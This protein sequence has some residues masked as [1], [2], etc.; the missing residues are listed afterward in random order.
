MRGKVPPGVTHCTEFA[1]NP[2][3]ICG[4]LC[5]SPDRV[6]RAAFPGLLRS[7]TYSSEVVA[8]GL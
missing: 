2:G 7:L 1:L 3:P 4:E 5:D 8:Q 6:Y